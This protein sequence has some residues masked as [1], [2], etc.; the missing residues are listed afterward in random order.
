MDQHPVSDAVLLRY[1]EKSMRQYEFKQIS[2]TSVSRQKQ[3]VLLVSGQGLAEELLS[4]AGSSL[5]LS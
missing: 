4:V 1:Y 2:N 3:Q 5:L